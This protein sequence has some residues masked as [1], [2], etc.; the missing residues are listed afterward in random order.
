[1]LG[2]G[3]TNY[4]R[5]AIQGNYVQQASTT[6]DCELLHVLFCPFD[7]LFPV[8]VPKRWVRIERSFPV[9]IEK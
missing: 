9:T 6:I 7:A 1:M 3:K 4:R 2:A 5:F 8:P